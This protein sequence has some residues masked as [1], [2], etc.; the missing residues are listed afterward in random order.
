MYR[1]RINS[2]V[3]DPNLDFKVTIFFNV[4]YRENDTEIYTYNKC[5]KTAVYTQVNGE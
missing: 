5:K 4:K 3:S 1:S 2:Q